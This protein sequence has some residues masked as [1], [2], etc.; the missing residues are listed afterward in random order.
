M[1][2]GMTLAAVTVLTGSDAS[3]SQLTAAEELRDYCAKMG[4]ESGTI[5]LRTD[6]SLGENGYR[7]EQQQDRVVISGSKA[8]GVLNGAYGYLQ[9]KCGVEWLSSYCEVVPKRSE[10]VRIGEPE[11]HQPAFQV[12]CSFWEDIMQNPRLGARL[13]MNSNLWYRRDDK[14]GPD[15]HRVD[16]VFIFAHS[17]VVS[18]VPPKRY[19]EEHPEWFCE[20]GGQ[21]QSRNPQLCFTNEELFEFVKGRLVE[22]VRRNPNAEIFGFGLGDWYNDCTC[23]KCRPINAREGTT[24]GTY[25]EFVN[26]LADVLREVA[27]RA[28]L[29]TSIYQQTGQP[30]KTIRLRDNIALDWAPIDA[31][32]D[33]PLTVAQHPRSTT[34]MQQIEGYRR[35]HSG[36]LIVWDYTTDFA[37][38]LLPMANLPTLQPN[39]KLFRDLGVYYVFEQG[40]HNGWHGEFSELKGWLLAQWLWNPDLDAKSLYR[41]FV[42]GFYGKP[43]ATYV[44]KYIKLLNDTIRESPKHSAVGI[45]NLPQHRPEYFEEAFLTKA[46][47]LW[48][49]AEQAARGDAQHSYNVR[50]SALP[51]RYV[52]CL[53]YAKN[54]NLTRDLVALE[55]GREIAKRFV[56][57]LDE[58]AAAGHPVDFGETNHDALLKRLREF[59][60]GA[61]FVGDGNR[62]RIGSRAFL[63]TCWGSVCRHV[64]DAEGYDGDLIYLHNNDYGWYPSATLDNVAFDPDT[65]YTLR[66]RVKV[67]PTG[68]EGE[69]FSAGIVD[70]TTGKEYSRKVFLKDLQNGGD[71][72][73]YDIATWKPGVGNIS[74]LYAAAGWFD[75]QKFELSPAHEGVW[76]D[77]FEIVRV[78]K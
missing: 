20:I 43:S 72:A 27:P 7:F 53:K 29:K 54:V 3:R 5:E 13:R 64:T 44:Y 18:V 22:Q 68:K 41:R 1:N 17:S 59:A 35:I 61:P 58:A 39:L 47:A 51:I 71:W 57:L 36:K 6:E 78:G 33:E 45:W 32:R 23:T 77:G 34:C 15:L 50:M 42:E 28:M 14:F 65:E 75:K 31:V 4:I 46:A 21:R 10:L 24:G 9:D 70:V 55:K 19:F 67:K 76:V 69:L 2:I 8:R 12:R 56:A 16:D 62:A 38:Y 66:L 25:W 49:A 26:R 63:T 40:D 60:G 73:W 74:Y 11:V 37:E 48:D 30:P 52:Q